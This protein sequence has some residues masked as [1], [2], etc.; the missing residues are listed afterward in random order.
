MSEKLKRLI[1]PGIAVLLIA[2]VLIIAYISGGK[3][4]DKAP[5]S[6]ETTGTVSTGL[7]TVSA[8]ETTALTAVSVTS[9][10]AES[11]ITVSTVTVTESVSETSS[12]LSA[13]TVQTKP[14]VT[15]SVKP[16]T[17]VTQAATTPSVT[18]ETAPPAVSPKGKTCSFM[19][20]CA[21]VFDNPEKLVPGLIDYLPKDGMIFPKSEVEFH[22]G[23]TVYDLTAR[24]CKENGISFES[25]KIAMTTN[26]YIEGI[27]DL[28]EFDA[29]DLSGWMYSVNG[30][31]PQ[32]S[33]SQFA[34]SEGDVIEV[35]Y[36]CN[37]GVDVGDDYFSKVG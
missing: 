3:V 22:D 13:E 1:K 27:G 6:G 20:S 7:Q 23:E 10:P 2:A 9:A 37:I 11:V 29:G 26:K 14:A 15:S 31:F 5:S 19:I 4:S 32:M 12:S 35:V 24:I 21:T 16:A 34:V 18:S 30:K 36:S 8:A 28:Y 17:Q 33:T 25:S